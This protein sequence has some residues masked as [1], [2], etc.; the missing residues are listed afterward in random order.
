MADAGMGGEASAT[1]PVPALPGCPSTPVLPDFHM[2]TKARHTGCLVTAEVPGL[3]PRHLKHSL[4]A[5]TLLLRE[6]SS[7]GAG[8]AA[9]MMLQ[10]TSEVETQMPKHFLL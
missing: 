7:P 3:P 8:D 4:L 2:G 10:Q 1:R 5:S 9:G 6:A